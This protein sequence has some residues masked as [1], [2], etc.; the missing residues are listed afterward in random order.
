MA[1]RA[2]RTQLI[3]A[4]CLTAR[5]LPA[6]VLFAAGQALAQSSPESAV[7]RAL[8]TRDQLTAARPALEAKAARD[9]KARQLLG[10]LNQ[11]LERGD[12]LPGDLI[13]MNVQGEETL[14][15]T[16]T[17]AGD[18]TL[19][20]PP[21]TVGELPL[22]GVLRSELEPQVRRFVARFVRIPVVRATPLVRVSI[23][24]EVARPG[25]YGVPA[26]EPVT[27]AI[28]SAG[29]T[30]ANADMRKLKI[31]RNGRTVA[32]G[33]RL[34]RAINEGLSLEDA[35]VR[36]GD[37]ILVARK[38]NGTFMESARLLSFMISIAGGL[39]GLSRIF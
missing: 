17:V 30:T 9:E 1:K 8:A 19:R 36:P 4:V 16:F 23:Q 2:L 6:A 13:L 35:S 32:T 3:T 25:F 39:Y 18:G 5:L 21:P 15:D 11:R 20:L 12:F 26:D 34:Q 14:S 29:G 31:N 22:H 28:M 37:E 10:L 24:G 33:E 7:Y 27:G 38:R